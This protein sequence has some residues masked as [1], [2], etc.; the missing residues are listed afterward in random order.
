MAGQI[1]G[2]GIPGGLVRSVAMIRMDHWRR[3][4][5]GADR[6]RD[7]ARTQ[8]FVSDI[9]RS[10]SCHGRS[11]ACGAS[12]CRLLEVIPAT[13]TATRREQPFQL[14]ERD[15]QRFSD[16]IAASMDVSTRHQFFTW[17][18]SSVQG[19]VPHEI[20]LCGVRDQSGRG[21]ALHRFSAT[22]YFRDEHFDAVADPLTG[23]VP[24]VL[25]IAET[26]GRTTVLCHPAL[27]H[28]AILELQRQVEA[29]ELKNLAAHLVRGVSGRF[30]AMY[31]FGRVG[32]VSELRVA[33]MVELLVPHLHGAFLRV[34][35]S[36][37]EMLRPTLGDTEQV[38]TRRQ[39]QILNL[40]KAGK[41]NAEIADKLGCSQWTVKNHVQ[42]ILRR[43]GSSSRTHA[44]SRAISLGILTAE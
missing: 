31:A 1:R 34:L 4:S 32:A 36:E 44:I 24:T 39:I 16:V 38:I 2:A 11:I 30:E 6:S 20:L 28:P 29:N 3:P 42:S 35:S 22:R 23:L 14:D 41:T 13:A 5:A 10:Q 27:S 26:T 17:L 40:V 12:P 18:H 15:I 7:V 25:G 43:L 21:M 8:G 33:W 19:L 37:R 9:T